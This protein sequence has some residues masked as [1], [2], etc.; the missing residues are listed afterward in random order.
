MAGIKVRVPSR[1]GPGCM[2]Q[3]CMSHS[4]S[5]SVCTCGGVRR[6]YKIGYPLGVDAVETQGTNGAV[7]T[8]LGASDSDKIAY[9]CEHNFSS[10]WGC[11]L[12]TG[13]V[14]LRYKA[15]AVHQNTYDRKLMVMMK[16]RE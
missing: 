12:N 8:W 16:L 13:E 15:P 5:V 3:G 14:D 1:T 7:S 4:P 2:G 10:N 6:F 11:N 9:R